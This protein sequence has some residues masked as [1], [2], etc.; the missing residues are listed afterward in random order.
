MSRQQ[1]FSKD[2]IQLDI[3]EVCKVLPAFMVQEGNLNSVMYFD[4][5]LSTVTETL[6]GYLKVLK[7]GIRV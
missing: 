6:L 7:N 3:D 2:F 5:I 4:E 1:V